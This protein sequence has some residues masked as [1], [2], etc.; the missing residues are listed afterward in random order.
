MYK[1]IELFYKPA[2]IVKKFVSGCGCEMTRYELAFLCGV[3][4][5]KNP[6]K[7]VEVGVAHGGT[8]CVIMECLRILNLDVEMHSVDI[9]EQCY[10]IPDK[11]TGYAVSDVFTEI[12]KNINH[13]WHLGKSLPEEIE[14]IG[15]GIDLLILDTMHIMPGEML[16]FLTA[17]PY[18]AQGA[19]VVLHDTILNL[20]YID[21]LLYDSS[22]ATGVVYDTVV[23]DRI[24]AEGKDA[25]YYL[26]NIGAFEINDDT[27]KYIGNCFSAL[28]ITW[29]YILEDKYVDQ[30]RKI[31]KKHYNDYFMDLF[32]KAYLLNVDRKRTEER[33]KREENE[34]NEEKMTGFHKTVSEGYKI[35]LYGGG[36]YAAKIGNYINN[37][38][39]KCDAY[40]V[41]DEENIDNCKIKEKIYHY[42]ELPY[43]QEE[44]NLIMAL[45]ADKQ[46][47]I[48]NKR[49][50]NRFH[51]VFSG[52][53]VFYYRLLEAIDGYMLIAKYIV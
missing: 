3:I 9:S 12:P 33:L 13:H 45:S 10:R 29:K 35:V 34:E 38:G 5:E 25:N 27:E 16:D 41:S 32:D 1:K 42:S 11:K 21:G 36:D 46:N 44:C 8:T 37:I 52:D 31:Y 28:T 22:Y 20:L 50:N 6:K 24:I 18:L 15:V 39:Y 47:L 7:I 51:N 14:E 4:K 48:L 23:G 2:D 43:L 53:A 26:P 19:T 17:F 49:A 30:Y 40:V